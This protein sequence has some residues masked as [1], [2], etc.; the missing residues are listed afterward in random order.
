MEISPPVLDSPNGRTSTPAIISG[1][2]LA[3]RCLALEWSSI[4]IAVCCG[5]FLLCVLLRL[6]GS[7]SALWAKDLATIDEP[8]GLI[9]GAPR[10][11]RSDEWLIWTP[12]ALAQL[13]HLP[14]LPVKNPALGAGAAP[15]LM[16]VPVRHYSMLFRPQFWGFFVFDEERG[17]AWFW[18][19]KIFGLLL[20][21]FFLF[22]ML[23]RGRVALAVVGSVA[24]SY[25]SYMQWFFSC[26]PMLPEMLASWA[27]MLLAG[28]ICFDPLP[29]WK[30]AA[31][32]V[33]LVGSAINF[34]LCC[35]PP[36]E[37][38]L[39]YLALILFGV[40][41]WERRATS[42][43]GGF[44]WVAGALVVTVAV[45]WPI[46]LQCRSTLE[47]IAQTSYPGV[48][49]ASGG[50]MPIAHLFSGV[51]NFFEGNR[52]RP[53]M[54][55]NATEAS[56]FFPIWLAAI[57]NI[58]WR[59]WKSR[60]SGGERMST[61]SRSTPLC[62]G[63]AGYILFFSFYA[64]VGFPEW[65]CRVTALNFCLETRV[66]LT[67]GI[68]GLM[69]A[70][71]SLGADG[72]ALVRGRSR[73][74]VPVVIGGAVLTYLLCIRGGNA[75]YLTPG[76]ALLLI[77]VTTLLGSLYFC[78]R[79]IVFGCALAGALLL[80]NFLV[81]P[82]SEGLPVL[83][84]SQASRHIAAIYKSDP[85]AGWAV[86]ERGTRAQLVMAS[87]ARVLNGMKSVPDLPVLTRLDPAQTSR[88]IYNRYAF[89]VL[90][91]PRPGERT[92]SFQLQGPDWYRAFVS[93]LDQAMRD[94]GL[95]YVVFPRLLKA[96]EMG[97]MTLL[98]ALPA[99]LIWIYKL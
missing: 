16:S 39:V 99:N 54:F 84:H 13:H 75:A 98:D 88:D 71:L 81:N 51:L 72:F 20:S 38:P 76:Y 25:S 10:P 5:L 40:F 93:P 55:Q 69:L 74:I 1:Q 87:G 11:T 58:C 32:G 89:M 7:S 91:L 27:L 2:S 79:G 28:K 18:N 30:K 67:I 80:N 62:L 65:F 70:F 36:F 61:I 53:A 41:L 8:T 17:F 6:N 59:L 66:R 73:V 21:F 35:Y 86:Y 9:A 94:Q 60:G 33:V 29:V 22:R 46:F 15:L 3:H 85:T 56:N 50:N 26:P 47:I 44:A 96:E 77:G 24:V 64:I 34:I 45:L 63:L 95:R 78:A 42:F 52:A 90:D 43:H 57:G 68:A 83:L 49:R 82:I 97:T 37:I 31:A 19:T 14:P 4:F 23:M 92:A 48:R 12:A